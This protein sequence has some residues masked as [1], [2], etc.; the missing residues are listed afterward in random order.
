[1]L[2]GLV[3][4]GK[5]IYKH[6]AGIAVTVG[7]VTG[8]A[9]VVETARK[10]VKNTPWI[11]DEHEEKMEDLK[12]K[13]MRRDEN[14]NEVL[15]EELTDAEVKEFK[16]AKIKVY[17]ETGWAL[18]KNYA[19]ALGL[20]AVSITST[21]YSYKVIK[22]QYVA[23]STAYA[24]LSDK[25][26]KYRNN[27]VEAYG[28]T[29]DFNAMNDIQT[30]TETDKKG[31]VTKTTYLSKREGTDVKIT[32]DNSYWGCFDMTNA[33]NTII[34]FKAMMTEQQHRLETGAIQGI[35][36]SSIADQLD[37][38]IPFDNMPLDWKIL[39]YAADDVIDFDIAYDT[40]KANWERLPY[41][42]SLMVPPIEITFKNVSPVL[43]II[44]PGNDE[45]A[46][47]ENTYKSM[48]NDGDNA[49]TFVETPV[50]IA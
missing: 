2:N 23:V 40:N 28:E 1:M 34:N 29:A 32:L 44:N 21:L 4:I 33:G 11:L 50:E 15:K 31:N 43:S 46:I 38:Y 25:F 8:V 17:K 5:A 26:A 48:V 45:Y 22:G 27:I 30:V 24:A 6:R 49:E 20:G 41:S 10:S 9:C 35:T 16:K 42:D 37:C 12:V 3:K 14:D 47:L 19:V 39:G 36:L 18:T 13:Y 7:V